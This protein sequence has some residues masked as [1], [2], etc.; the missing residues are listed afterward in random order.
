MAGEPSYH[1][2]FGLKPL[3]QG[4]DLSAKFSKLI[5]PDDQQLAE[6]A[7]RKMMLEHAVPDIE[8]RIIKENGKLTYIRQKGKL[9]MHG[10]NEL[11]IVG[12]IED[13]TNEKLLK[14]KAV[15]AKNKSIVNQLTL[16]QTEI[17]TGLAHWI[18]K[19]QTGEIMWSEGFYNLLGYKPNTVTLTQKLVLNF[20]H[21]DDRE[22][23]TEHLA[24]SLKSSSEEDFEFRLIR[25]GEIKYIK[26]SFRVF[27]YENESYFLALMQDITKEFHLRKDAEKQSQFTHL[28]SDAINDILLVTDINYRILEWNKRSE[29]SFAKEKTEVLYQNFFD[30][31]PELKVE[32]IFTQFRKVLNGETVNLDHFTLPLLKKVYNIYLAPLHDEE[33]NVKGIIHI[34]RD[35]TKEFNLQKELCERLTFI[36]KLVE[37]SI[38]RIVVLDSKMHFVYWNKQAEAFYGIAKKQ[39][40]GKNIMDVFP[41]TQ[42]TP[43]Y[44]EFRKALKGETVYIPVEESVQCGQYQESFLIPIKGEKEEVSSIL[45]IMHDV[46]KDHELRLQQAK[47]DTILNTIDEGFYELDA[48]L[49]FQYINKECER[50][51]AVKKE[52]LLGRVI[53]EVFPA[54]IDS[55]LY[56][57]IQFVMEEKNIV[58]PEYIS[59]ITNRW[60]SATIVP[61]ATGVI[62]FSRDIHEVK[63]AN[64]K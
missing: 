50:L 59:P 32:Y 4:I 9:L 57:A 18:W 21:P 1:R 11:M 24:N 49:R 48:D 35:V 19:I 2:I 55:V 5:H 12:I 46:T 44:I 62:V 6:E 15:I 25:R 31:F 47:A 20:V 60:I 16:Q 38:D 3:Q 51:W 34:F 29:E 17:T 37:S 53:W 45:W 64:T 7:N 52:D 61:S 13:I 41:G 56:F 36:E 14:E 39:V 27:E 54:A 58:R 23:F 40:I 8:Y 26:A 43:S 28:I 33:Q 42:Q 30:V 63:T 10:N 22:S